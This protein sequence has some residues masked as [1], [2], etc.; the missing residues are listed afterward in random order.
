MCSPTSYAHER[1]VPLPSQSL[2]RTRRWLGGDPYHW[3]RDSTKAY[4]SSLLLNL[5]SD[6]NFQWAWPGSLHSEPSGPPCPGWLLSGY[7]SPRD[8]WRLH[9]L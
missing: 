6:S 7:H 4:G 5:S 8:T 3:D 9:L 2:P 1:A